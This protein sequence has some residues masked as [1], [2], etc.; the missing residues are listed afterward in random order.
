MYESINMIMSL[1]GGI[2]LY[3]TAIGKIN[4]AL[5]KET[6]NKYSKIM[7]TVA[8]F[9]IFFPLLNFAISFFK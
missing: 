4:S 3:L 8:I 1:V 2:L 9:L 7:K 6:I 5:E